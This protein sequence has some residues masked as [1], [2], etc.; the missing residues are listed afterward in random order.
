MHNRIIVVITVA[1]LLVGTGIGFTVGYYA[2][3]P[4]AKEPQTISVFAAGSMTYALGTGFY[5]QFKNITGIGVAPTFGGSVSGAS[6]VDAGTPFDVF[7][8]AAAGVIPQYLFANKTASWMVIFAS[9]EMAITWLNNSLNIT[10]PYW[11]ENL[12][13]PGI[14][15]GVSNASLDP[16]GFQ[17]IEMLKLA[18]LL[19]TQYNS[20]ATIGN[21]TETVGNYVKE[22]W[23][24]NYTLYSKYNA[25]WND[26]FGHNGSLVKDNLGNGYPD[27]YSLAL[28]YQIFNYSYKHGNLILTTEEYGLDAYLKSGAV[29]YALTYKSQ[30]INQKLNYYKTANGENGLSKW[31]NLGN[32]SKDV[33][34]F[35]GAVTTGGPGYSNIGNFPGGPILYSGTIISS[36]KNIQNAQQ[37]I[38]YLVTNLGDSM[39]AKSDF[40]PIPVPFVYA[41]TSAAPSFLDGVTQSVPVYIPPSSYEEV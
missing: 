21:S 16:S 6:E 26:W 27:N 20:T 7:I 39:L 40:N 37:L 15:V 8:S 24:N 19:Y 38:Y 23:G 9:N 4:T 28:Y 29:N 10:T 3:H 32:I 12:T 18:G 36:S 5:P 31:I 25:A 2:G 35:Y 11:F 33:D 13:S 22:A 30:A 14:K 34:N 1:M 17:A 41:P